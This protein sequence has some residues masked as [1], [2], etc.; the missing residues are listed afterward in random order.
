MELIYTDKDGN[1][2]KYTQEM[3]TAALD[4][5]NKLRLDV[6]ELQTRVQKYWME[7]HNIQSRVYNFFKDHYDSG[8]ADI[9][10]DTADV[11]D[12]LQSI[13]SERLKTLFTVTGTIN[14]TLTDVEAEDA[15]D[16]REIAER[17]LTV[18]YD[19]DGSLDDWD[20]E[21]GDTSEQ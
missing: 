14:F 5:R 1:Q 8:D 18:T 16:A 13:G 15:D 11:N 20:V 7:I 9:T 21:V 3:I 2:T 19:G 4:E 10:C 17:E 12:F 6:E